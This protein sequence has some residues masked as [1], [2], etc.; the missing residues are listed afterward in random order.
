M[1]YRG[2]EVVESKTSYLI[3]G[4]NDILVREFSKDEATLDTVRQYI[5]KIIKEKV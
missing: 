1:I 5:N 4:D 2:Y 3:Y